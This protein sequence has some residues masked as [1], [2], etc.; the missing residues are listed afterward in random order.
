MHRR[1]LFR[2]HNHKNLPPLIW[3]GREI[4][5]EEV[6]ESLAA[7]LVMYAENISLSE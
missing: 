7:W 3:K 5:F 2:W 4:V 1:V 6:E